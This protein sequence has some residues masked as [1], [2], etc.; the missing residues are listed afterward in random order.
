MTSL[1]GILAEAGAV[2]PRVMRYPL[3]TADDRQ[4]PHVV[5]QEWPADGHC[6]NTAPVGAGC[7]LQGAPERPSMSL[8]GRGATGSEAYLLMVLHPQQ[9]SIPALPPPESQKTTIWRRWKSTKLQ[10]RPHFE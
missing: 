8:D 2:G 7:R 10:V 4:A 1:E 6:S 5:A 3:R 9:E